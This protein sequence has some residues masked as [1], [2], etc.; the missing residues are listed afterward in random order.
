MNSRL[1]NY[2]TMLATILSSRS[3][4][5]HKFVRPMGRFAYTSTILKMSDVEGEYPKNQVYIGNLP[6][7]FGEDKL[8]EILSSKVGAR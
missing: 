1:L 6:F 8:S 5:I 2:M 3:F 4:S 7:E